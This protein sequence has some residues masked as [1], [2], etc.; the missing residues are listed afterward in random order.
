L[1][2]E[3]VDVFAIDPMEVGRTDLVDHNIETSEHPLILTEC[4]FCVTS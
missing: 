3:Y 4:H 2:Q 1:I